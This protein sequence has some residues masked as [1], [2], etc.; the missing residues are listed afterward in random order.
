MEKSSVAKHFDYFSFFKIVTISSI[1]PYFIFLQ[2]LAKTWKSRGGGIKNKQ[3]FSVLKKYGIV[4]LSTV[5][6]RLVL[7]LRVMIL[8]TERRKYAKEIYE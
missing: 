2:K 3:K 5:Y 8:T 4:V 1:S 7:W 6:K